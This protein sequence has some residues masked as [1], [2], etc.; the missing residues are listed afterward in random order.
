MLSQIFRRKLLHP[1]TAR[2][3]SQINF[4]IKDFKDSQWQ[5]KGQPGQ[6][7]MSAGVEAGVPFEQACGGN[8]ECCT[9][10][11]YVPLE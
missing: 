8:A 10:H 3:F 2:A 7:I 5:V 9:C 1:S 11:I 4:T 6:T